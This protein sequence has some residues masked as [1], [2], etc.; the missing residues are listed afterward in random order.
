MRYAV[1]MLLALG[2]AKYGPVLSP[3]TFE[4]GS[5]ALSEKDE[6]RVSEAAEV[7]RDSEWNVLVI[8]LADVAGDAAMNKDL[9][10]RRANEVAELLKKK[11]PNVPAKRIVTHTIGE[12]LSTGTTVQERKVEFVFYKDSDLTPKEIVEA[13]GVMEE[14][15][16]RAEKKKK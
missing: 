13:S 12:K 2:C 1:L 5:S 7:L 3:V 11:C 9:A 14:D 4:T 10:E 16:H 6:A 15:F 8:G